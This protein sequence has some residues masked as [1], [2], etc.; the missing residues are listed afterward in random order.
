M[1]AELAFEEG[2]IPVGA[3]VVCN[4][5][6]IAKAHNQVEKLND[7]TAHA[8]ILAI[9][10]AQNYL[11]SK[12]LNE[13]ALYVTLKPCTMCAGALYWSMIGK[14]V[15][16]ATD[17]KRGYHLMISEILHPSTEVVADVMAKDS[18]KLLK[19]F[20]HNLRNNKY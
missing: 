20:F 1:E 5:K 18:A 16:A 9:T 12:Y 6:I 7:A 17:Q 15:Y 11:G 8:E 14:V 13:C 2:E 4:H 19:S 3:A 10:A